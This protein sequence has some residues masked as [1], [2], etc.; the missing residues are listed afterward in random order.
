ME[1]LQG[2]DR[3]KI[4]TNSKE[5]SD[6]KD[7]LNNV[8]NKIEDWHKKIIEKKDGKFTNDDDFVEMQQSPTKFISD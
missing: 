2:S 1:I 8:S 5:F 6:Y 3:F 7:L 4:A